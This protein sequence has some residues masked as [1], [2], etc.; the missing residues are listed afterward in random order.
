VPNRS[1]HLRASKQ[2]LGYANPIVHDILDNQSPTLEH[3]YRHNPRTAH[4]IGEWFGKDAEREAW[5]HILMDWHI[6]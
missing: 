6:I 2:L 3:R 1:S 5:L 4:Q